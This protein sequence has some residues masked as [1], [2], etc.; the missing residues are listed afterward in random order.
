M[1]RLGCALRQCAVEGGE[2]LR[3]GAGG[4]MQRIGEVYAGF[5]K[6]QYAE[7][8]APVFHLKVSKPEKAAQHVEDHVRSQ[9]VAEA[10]DP[11]SLQK[12]GLGNPE[13]EGLPGRK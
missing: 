7:D 11:L 13:L 5:E 6:G 10:K 9:L 2:A 3:V 12:H 4:E 8:G 1:S